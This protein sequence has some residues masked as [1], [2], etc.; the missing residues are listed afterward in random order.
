VPIVVYE[1]SV[2]VSCNFWG[3][4]CCTPSFSN[5]ELLK[6]PLLPIEA[7]R[8]AALGETRGNVG[9]FPT[10]RTIY[11]RQLSGGLTEELRSG[12]KQEKADGLA[13]GMPRL[14]RH[15]E[16]PRLNETPSLSNTVAYVH[17]N[18]ILGEHVH[19]IWH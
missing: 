4:C 10:I 17:S 15:R 16:I 1:Q 13:S 9:V 8:V 14:G 2:R 6:L 12:V 3:Q 11:T 5:V 7:C 19:P 18:C